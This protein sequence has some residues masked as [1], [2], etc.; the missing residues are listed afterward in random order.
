MQC[1]ACG[2]PLAETSVVSA[3]RTSEGLVCY[4]RCVCGRITIRLRPPR[5]AAGAA[6]TSAPAPAEVLAA[7]GGQ[8][9]AG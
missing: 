7:S 2:W 4:R 8:R 3:H 9:L 6:S 1:T 5:R